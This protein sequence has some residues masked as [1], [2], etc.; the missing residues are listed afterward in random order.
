MKLKIQ[1]LP[2]FHG[3]AICLKYLGEDSTFHNIFI[4]S[5]FVSSYSI[6]QKEINEIIK[7]NEKIDL[8]IITHIDQDHIGGI[9]AYMQ[10]SSINHIDEVWFNGENQVSFSNNNKIS[11][12]QGIKLSNYLKDNGKLK[13]NY[14]CSNT[15]SIN[16]FGAELTILSPNEKYLKEFIERWPEENMIHSKNSPI[17][18]KA[19]DYKVPIPELS[20][21]AF[22]EDDRFEHR[23]CITFI[24]RAQGI[25]ILFLSDIIPSIIY[26]SLVRLGYNKNN[27]LIVDYVK[28]S[29]HASKF[30]TNNEL[31]SLIECNNYIISAN[32]KNEYF[33]PHKETLSRIL[34]NPERNSLE[35]IHFLFNYDNEVIRSIF[36]TDDLIDYNFSCI[37]PDKQGNAYA[38]EY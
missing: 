32:G 22:L 16:L 35:P 36:S 13:V 37:F 23:S 3:D 11:F 15:Q 29:H 27:K 26:E 5:G 25:S 2:V 24:F 4:D 8:W 17:S 30:N 1:I 14:V 18:A 38:I 19:N 34:L 10:K 12:K 31:L 28:L 33:L 6:I 20:K 9:L 7:V 21:K